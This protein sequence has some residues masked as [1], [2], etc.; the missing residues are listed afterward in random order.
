MAKAATGGVVEKSTARGT[1]YALRFRA[2]GK[3]QF[4]HLGYASEGWTRARA[5]SELDNVLADVRRGQWQ[6]PPDPAAEA[7]AV[8]EIPTFHQ[9]ASEW[10]ADQKVEGGRT[11]TGLTESGAADLE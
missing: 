3:R 9:F 6:P 1:S 10:F 7:T 2:L 4:I 8:R 5:E 11:G